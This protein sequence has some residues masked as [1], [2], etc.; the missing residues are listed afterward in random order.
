VFLGDSNRYR[1]RRLLQVPSR[2][3]T[4]SEHKVHEAENFKCYSDRSA[5]DFGSY[6]LIHY[7]DFLP[8]IDTVGY[9][10]EVPG[11]PRGTMHKAIP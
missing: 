9:S 10:P 6:K 3:L 8:T 7:R 5:R 11:I 4:I 2:S 1:L